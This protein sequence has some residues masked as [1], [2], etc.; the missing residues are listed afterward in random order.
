M[1]WTDTQAR[2][3]L[4]AMFDA[5]VRSADPMQVLARHLPDR[6]PGRVVVVGAGKSAALMAAAV[7]AAWP[8]QTLEGVVVTRY[9][10][11]CPTRR[12][13]VIQASHPVPDANS[14]LGARRV[15]DSVRGLRPDDLVL[16]PMSGG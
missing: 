13:E 10:H 8:D 2:A 5:G 14:E 15:L 16:V 4:R 9:Q 7:E 6:P 1:T 11:A 12:I 3:A